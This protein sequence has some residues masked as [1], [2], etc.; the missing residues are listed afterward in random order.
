M[1]MFHAGGEAHMY[2]VDAF[3][4]Q[5]YSP[6]HLVIRIHEFMKTVAT[7]VNYSQPL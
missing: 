7:E 1:N 4:K 2:V 6:H 5:W 3:T